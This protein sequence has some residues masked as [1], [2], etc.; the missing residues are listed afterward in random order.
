M[1]EFVQKIGSLLALAAA[2][3]I[4]VAG[5]TEGGASVYPAGVE[6]VMPG[7]MP[8]S[9]GTLFLEFD[10][11]YQA[12]SLAGPT[13]QSLVPG[14]HLRVSAVAP[15]FVHN[16]GLHLLGG[17]LVSSAAVPFLYEHL[18][19]PFGK[20]SKSGV[21]NPDFGV[22]DIAYHR[23]AWHWWYGVDVFTPGAQYDKGALLNI[24]QHNYATA[25]VGAFTY[26]PNGGRTELSS[27][28]EYIVNFTDPATNYRSGHELIWEY[29]AMQS[30]TKKL[31]IGANGDY[32]QQ[33]TD[34]LQNGLVLSGTRARS[35]MV[36]PEIRYHL[37]R[38]ELILKYQKETLAQNKPCGNSFW[39]QIGLPLGHH[40]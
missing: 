16:W 19:A 33:T 10:N 6:T 21:G 24:G 7:L 27:R 38:T 18:N 36:G 30:V 26:L 20:G 39:F 25:P 23:G 2:W 28:V 35:V 37:G 32:Y 15:K 5:A 12:N 14:F 40:E 17:E 1:P 13:G 4:G 31:A 34:D 29:D 9:G 3:T 11:F 8:G 22:A